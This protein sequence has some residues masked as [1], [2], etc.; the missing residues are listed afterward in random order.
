[1][2]DIVDEVRESQNNIF[3]TGSMLSLALAKGANLKEAF[4]LYW[5]MKK[6]IFLE[7]STMGRLFGDQVRHFNTFTID[8]NLG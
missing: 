1:M 4:F 7:G 8:A 6:M 3:S 5:D 2:T